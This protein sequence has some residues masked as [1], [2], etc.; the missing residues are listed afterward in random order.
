M[1][2]DEIRKTP[3][4]IDTGANSGRVHESVL[5]SFFILEKVQELL[6]KQTPAEVILELIADMRGAPG[7]DF[8]MASDRKRNC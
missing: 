2:L 3:T 8:V 7:S 1:T 4:I 6:T 5:R